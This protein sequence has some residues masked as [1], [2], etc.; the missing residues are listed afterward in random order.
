MKAAFT[1]TYNKEGHKTPYAIR[2]AA[3]KGKRG[4]SEDS[5]TVEEEG[6]MLE[7]S[8]QQGDNKDEDDNI[9]NSAM[10]KATKKPVKAGTSSK[11]RGGK[12]KDVAS[13]GAS[14]AKGKGKGKNRK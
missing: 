4:G 11:G 14:T 5:Q 9:E 12:P 10:I 3:K 8:E 7:E 1:R 13:K 6:Y 2:S